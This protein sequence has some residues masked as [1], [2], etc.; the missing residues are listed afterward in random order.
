MAIQSKEARVGRVPSPSLAHRIGGWLPHDPKSVQGHVKEILRRAK[1]ANLPDAPPVKELRELL[2][3]NPNVFMLFTE[4]L[5]EV[6]TRPPYNTIPGGGP[7]IRDL[8]TLIQALNYQIQYPILYNDSPQIGTPINAILDWPMATKAGFAAFIRDDVNEVFKHMLEY[9]GHYLRTRESV[10]PVTTD[11][12][13]WLSREAQ[14]QEA[15][16][17]NFLDTY[18]FFTRD[19][20][21]GLRPLACPHDDN[22]IVSATESTPFYIR[23]NVQLRDTF[24]VKNPDGRSNYSLADMLGDEGKAQ[25]FVGG[26]VYQAFLSADSYHNWHAPVSGSYTECPKII[27]GAYHSE[28]LMWGFSPDKGI[29]HPD[30]SADALSQSYL[31]AVAKRGVAYIQADNPDIGLMAVVMIGMAEVSSVDF[32]DKPNGFKKGDKIGRFHFGGSTHCLIFGP[33]VKLSFNLDAIPNPGLQ[34]PG[35]PIHV[36]SRLAT[37]NPSNC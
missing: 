27:N 2:G 12:G 28:P 25:Q 22:V 4:M 15:G 19:F 6:P 21:H 29:A 8:E 24:W 10:Q 16:L 20:K 37:V 17:S 13:G 23:R 30:I 26:T 11:A 36:L 33:N 14:I 34:N 32:F 7:E 5:T 35:S 9:W 18:I 31:S 3:K 1:N